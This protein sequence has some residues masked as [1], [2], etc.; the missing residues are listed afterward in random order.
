MRAWVDVQGKTAGW[1]LPTKYWMA[2]IVPVPG[3]SF[4]AGFALCA[5]ARCLSDPAA[6]LPSVTV[7]PGERAQAQNPCCLPGQREWTTLRTYEAE[8]GIDRFIDA[9][10][11]G[12][13]FFLTKPIF[14]DAPISSKG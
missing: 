1:A 8:L 9:I 4:S 10:D 2:M 12:W 6:D 5:C 7:G 13:F 14:R 3:E 11:W